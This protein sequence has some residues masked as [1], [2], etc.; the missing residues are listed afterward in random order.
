LF[1]VLWITR[2]IVVGVIR[3]VVAEIRTSC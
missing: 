3:E 1:V 2:K